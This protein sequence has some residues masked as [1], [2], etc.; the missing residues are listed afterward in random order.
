MKRC[1][2]TLGSARTAQ[3]LNILRVQVQVKLLCNLHIVQ[4]PPILPTFSVHIG[5][6]QASGEYCVHSYL[7]M[8]RKLAFPL[9]MQSRHM[10]NG[11]SILYSKSCKLQLRGVIRGSIPTTT[12]MDRDCH[13]WTH[14]TGIWYQSSKYHHAIH[15]SYYN[16]N[17]PIPKLQFTLQVEVYS[18]LVGWFAS[19]TTKTDFCKIELIKKQACVLARE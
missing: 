17:D 1:F 19:I 10:L 18:K 14:T 7:F 4:E 12:R 6:M 15:G 8:D 2:W 16:H 9:S 5:T 13:S 11:S 3:Q